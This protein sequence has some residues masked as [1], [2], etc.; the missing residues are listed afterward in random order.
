MQLDLKTK[1]GTQI[2]HNKNPEKLIISVDYFE[3]MI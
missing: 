3:H 2:F 1:R